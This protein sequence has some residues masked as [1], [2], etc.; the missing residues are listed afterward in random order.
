[1]SDSSYVVQTYAK[2]KEKYHVH[3]TERTRNVTLGADNLIFKVGA[4]GDFRKTKYSLPP[5][6]IGRP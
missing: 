1:M 3:F 5:P 4:L 6:A 2:R